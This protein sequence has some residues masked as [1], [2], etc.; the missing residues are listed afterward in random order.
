MHGES[1][2]GARWGSGAQESRTRR[3]IGRDD[4]NTGSG[5]PVKQLAPGA[6][7]RLGRSILANMG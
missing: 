2:P 1:C 3:K 4:A 6:A 5:V 7:L